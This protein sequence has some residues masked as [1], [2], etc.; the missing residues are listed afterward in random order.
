MILFDFCSES[1]Q[2]EQKKQTKKKHHSDI[3][4]FDAATQQEKK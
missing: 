1:L 3:L 2:R 4:K